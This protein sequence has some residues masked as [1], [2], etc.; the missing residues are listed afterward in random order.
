MLFDKNLNKYILEL[1]PKIIENKPLVYT[2]RFGFYCIFKENID[3]NDYLINN[4]FDVI[5]ATSNEIK[6]D[7]LNRNEVT[8]K[9]CFWIKNKLGESGSEF[10]IL[11]IMLLYSIYWNSKFS[12]SNFDVKK[13]IILKELT[14]GIEELNYNLKV[15]FKEIIYEFNEIVLNVFHKIVIPPFWE[16]AETNNFLETKNENFIKVLNKYNQVIEESSKYLINF[17]AL[18]LKSLINQYTASDSLLQSALVLKIKEKMNEKVVL[19][20]DETDLISVVHSKMKDETFIDSQD[21]LSFLI[22]KNYLFGL[23]SYSN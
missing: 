14:S 17:N 23:L 16:K 15:S 20:K 10:E 6:S 9:L 11:K 21:L 3:L 1:K 8:K 18:S 7:G 13:T 2:D 5:N 19:S 12:L 22:R 4:L